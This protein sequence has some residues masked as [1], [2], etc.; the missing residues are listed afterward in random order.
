M[1]FAFEVFGRWSL[2]PLGNNLYPTGV[3]SD[4]WSLAPAVVTDRCIDY[5]LN[6][7]KP[8]FQSQGVITLPSQTP[9][10]QKKH[11][12][13]KPFEILSQI[14]IEYLI[15][16]DDFIHAAALPDIRPHPVLS[17]KIKRPLIA[18]LRMTER[19]PQ[20]YTPGNNHPVFRAPAKTKNVRLLRMQKHPLLD[21]PLGLFSE[22]LQDDWPLDSLPAFL[23]LAWNNPKLWPETFYRSKA[24]AKKKKKQLFAKGKNLGDLQILHETMILSQEYLSKLIYKLHKFSTNL[25]SVHD[26]GWFLFKAPINHYERGWYEVRS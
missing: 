3:T 24:D 4:L 5:W 12:P 9:L 21:V 14:C 19:Q 10:Q 23:R 7:E 15:R 16:R 18:T 26:L 25:K 1:I 8:P 13:D 6:L 22:G 2:I 20:P 17:C 11:K